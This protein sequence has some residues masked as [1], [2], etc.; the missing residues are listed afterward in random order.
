MFSPELRNAWQTCKAADPSEFEQLPNGKYIAR[1]DAVKLDDEKYINDKQIPACLTY[2]MTVTE[3][4]R[5]QTRCRKT[6]FING[7]RSFSYIKLDMN[8]LQCQIPANPDDIAFSLQNAVGKTV[9][10]EVKRNTSTSGKEF[11]NTY[12]KRL[13]NVMPA[14]STQRA[15]QQMPAQA[16]QMPPQQWHPAPQSQVDG[17]RQMVNQQPQNNMNYQNFGPHGPNDEIPF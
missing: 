6:D 4:E 16:P 11:I 17:Y 14:P 3:G 7:D 2:E 9:E 13:V 1:I 10:I 15:Q 5:A 8:T 12:I